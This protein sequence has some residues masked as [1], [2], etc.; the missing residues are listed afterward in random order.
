MVG[1]SLP[2]EEVQGWVEVYVSYWKAVG[3]I[4]AVQDASTANGKVS[5]FTNWVV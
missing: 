3:E 2:K 4:L 1:N 5:S